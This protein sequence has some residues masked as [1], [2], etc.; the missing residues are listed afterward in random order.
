[1]RRLYDP[2]VSSPGLV[3]FDCDGVLVDS[4]PV[5]N[6]VL[7]ATISEA[8]LEIE[9]GAVAREFEG[10]RLGEIVAR[11]GERLG[12]PLP[13][14]WIVDFEAR[15]A[16]EFEKGLDAIP[17]V[18]DALKSIR[19]AGIPVCV[20]SQASLEKTELTLGLT[21]L[22]RNFGP[23]SLFSS[24]MVANGKPDPDLFLLAARTMGCAPE[25]CVVVED[26]APG[27][28]AGRLA[29]MRVLGY[30]PA[31]DDGRLAREGAETFTSMAELPVLLGLSQDKP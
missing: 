8:G 16:A 13:D 5:S 2:A 18:A 4:E 24:Q 23:G 31:G 7:A 22:A 17:G 20:A 6:R 27:A 29:R 25:R 10:M 14:G 11:I 3:I 19:G 21:G 30:S 28:R 12:K 9:P 1:M 26:G 15:R